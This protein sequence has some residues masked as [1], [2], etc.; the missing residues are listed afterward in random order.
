MSL[1]IAIIGATGLVGQELIKLFEKSSFDVDFKLIASNKS[2]NKKIIIKNKSYLVKKLNEKTF[3]DVDFAF[4]MAGGGL[5]KK[6][7]PIAIKKN[8]I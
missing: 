8:V 6:Y 5:S 1:K 4:F 7:I 3:D 2:L